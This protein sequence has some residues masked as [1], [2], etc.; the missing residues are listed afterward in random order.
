MNLFFGRYIL[1][2][3]LR[4]VGVKELRPFILFVRTKGSPFVRMY[5]LLP[6]FNIIRVGSFS[7]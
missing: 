1:S 6:P 5:H 7:S 3:A 2:F 4:P